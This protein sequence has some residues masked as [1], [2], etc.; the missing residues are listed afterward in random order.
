[1]KTAIFHNYMDN[2]GGAEI[3]GLTL[4]REL[5]APIYTTN[6]DYEKIRKMGFP[7]VKLISIGKIPLNAPF[8][9]QLALWKFRRLDL[10]NKYDFYIIDGDWAMSGAVNNHPNLW[11][12]H[13]PIR[14][15]WDAYKYTRNNMVPAPLRG[16]FDLWVKCNRYLNKKYTEKVDKLVCNSNNTKN[17]LKKFLNKEAKVINPPI[18]TSKFHYRK[19]G[20]FWLSVN[21]LLPPKRVE[22]QINAFRKMP[23][24]KLVIVGSYEQSRNFLKYTAYLKSIKPRNVEITSWVDS[25]ELIELYANCKGFIA[26]AMDEDFGMTPIEAMASGKPVI[27]CNEGGYKETVINN[28]T[29]KLIGGI[30]E[31]K[32]IKAVKEMNKELEKQPEKYKKGCIKRAKE[33]DTKVFIK[34]MKGEIE[35]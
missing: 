4:A 31:E 25:K 26:T 19:N 21:R 28:I 12:V 1:M 23:H 14:E 35:R 22:M 27:A 3:V 2:I 17:R 33:F 10:K 7:D 15:I 20:N 9:Q 16:I 32:L 8:R 13:S 5:K 24:E 6:I 30:T 11:Y 34:K 18:E 29:G